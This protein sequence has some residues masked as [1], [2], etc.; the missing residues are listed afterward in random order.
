MDSL[1]E[2]V[3]GSPG[4]C[5]RAVIL[6]RDAR[7][8]DNSPGFPVAKLEPDGYRDVIESKLQKT[9]SHIARIVIVDEAFEHQCRF[10]RR[11]RLV[12]CLD[13]W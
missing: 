7:R 8:A 9:Q 11:R 10:L 6:R 4:G 5:G 2:P 1:R 13:L 3:D 12:V